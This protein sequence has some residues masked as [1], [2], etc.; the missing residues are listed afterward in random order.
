M[1]QIPLGSTAKSSPAAA[2]GNELPLQPH[3]AVTACHE[4]VLTEVHD[5][6]GGSSRWPLS[7]QMAVR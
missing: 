2:R 6:I 7:S 5:A 3:A 1:T 4:P